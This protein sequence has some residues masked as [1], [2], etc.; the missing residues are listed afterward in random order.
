MS[1]GQIAAWC[2]AGM[3]VGAH[4][5]THPRL[6]GLATEVMEEEVEGSRRDLEALADGPV[7]HFCYPYGD[8][9]DRVVDAV[10]RAGFVSATTVRRARARPDDDPYRQPRV[11]VRGQDP[12][13]R[14]LLKLFT[15]YVDSRGGREER[16]RRLS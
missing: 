5:R 13:P 3:E 15:P 16:R 11:L 1:R 12:L 7:S 4:T 14:F 10:R 9:D 8:L 2:A 6:V